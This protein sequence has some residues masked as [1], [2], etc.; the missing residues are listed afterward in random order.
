MFRSLL[1]KA[2]VA[3]GLAVAGIVLGFGLLSSSASSAQAIDPPWP[4][5]VYGRPTTFEAGGPNG[6]YFWRDDDGFQLCSTTPSDLLHPFIAVLK[7]EGQFHD[8]SKTRLEAA[9]DIDIRDGGKTLI[10]KF[11][12]H[13]GVDCAEFRT[14]GNKLNLKLTEFG[15]LIPKGRIFIGHFNVNPPANPF[16][17]TR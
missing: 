14:T 5:H 12:T 1:I 11:H 13:S 4:D 15:M 9:D 16:T 2:A 17:I 7:T 6:W 3:G 10:L 8:I